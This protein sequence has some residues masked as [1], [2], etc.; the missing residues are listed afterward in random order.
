MWAASGPRE[1][2]AA[3]L[4]VCACARVRAEEEGAQD[5]EAGGDDCDRGFDHGHGAG[6]HLFVA[7]GVDGADY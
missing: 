6:Y 4:A 2:V 3:P 7:V 1:L 5:G